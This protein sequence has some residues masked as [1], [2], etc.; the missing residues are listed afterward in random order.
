MAACWC[1]T[2]VWGFRGVRLAGAAITEETLAAPGVS[3]NGSSEHAL[4]SFFLEGYS[5]ENAKRVL[6]AV[7]EK[8][9]FRP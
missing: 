4:F 3:L 2:A 7:L 9:S 5:Q 6:D 1:Q 8:I